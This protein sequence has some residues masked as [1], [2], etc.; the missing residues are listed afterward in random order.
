MSHSEMIHYESLMKC[1]PASLHMR[2][3]GIYTYVYIC[4]YTYIYIFL[5]CFVH[6][7]GLDENQL[8]SSRCTA[9]PGIQSSR[10]ERHR[11]SLTWYPVGNFR[12]KHFD[13]SDSAL[14]LAVML[15][16]SRTIR[17]FKIFAYVCVICT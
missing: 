7:F 12:S 3:C 10:N 15:Q 14:K 5:I 6:W 2:I 8:F 4:K 13:H 17:S 1:E 9:R 11:I 16:Q